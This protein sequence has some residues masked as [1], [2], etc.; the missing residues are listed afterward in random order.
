MYATSN[1]SALTN[2][3]I[4]VQQR[5]GTTITGL[6]SGV[7]AEVL[8]FSGPIIVN[9]LGT[10]TATSTA[11]NAGS[12]NAG[13]SVRDVAVAGDAVNVTANVVN[14]TRMDGINVLRTNGNGG[15]TITA[16]GAI[17]SGA[18]TN[19]LQTGIRAVT[20]NGS[21][22]P[23]AINLNSAIGSAADRAQIGG[24]VANA[25]PTVGGD[26]QV[27]L[28]NGSVYSLGTGIAVTES[29]PGIVSVTG[30]GTGAINVTGG[31]GINTQIIG[32]RAGTTTVELS[33]TINASGNAIVSSTQGNGNIF[34][35][36]ENTVT[37]G[38]GGILLTNAGPAGNTGQLI[39][40]Q[41]AGTT[42][43]A[44]TGD[45]I[46]TT[47]GAAIGGTVITVNGTVRSTGAD[48]VDASSNS[49]R[50]NIQITGAVGSAITGSTNGIIAAVNG[51]GGDLQ[52]TTRGSVAATAGNGI[53]ALNNSTA[54]ADTVTVQTFGTVTA[55][56]GDGI[57]ATRNNG[58]GA[59]TV[60][61]GGL[62]SSGGAGTLQNGILALNN[63]GG[64][65]AVTLNAN[66]GSAA[67][68]AVLAGVAAEQSV[69][70][71]AGNVTLALNTASVFATGG[72]AVRATQ[73]GDGAVTISETGTGLISS[74]NGKGVVAEIINGGPASI[75]LSLTHAIQSG[76]D[77]LTAQTD[78][79]G[80]L[81]VVQ[82]GAITSTNGVGILAQNTNAAASGSIINVSTPAGTS[83][84]AGNDAIRTVANLA[85]GGTTI[86]TGGNLSSTAGDGIDASSNSTRGNIAITTATGT[87]ITVGNGANGIL[88]QTLGGTGTAGTITVTNN[89]G[90]T[91]GTTSNGINAR[92]G[93]TVAGD[94]LTVTN[95]GALAVGS[96]GIL[97]SR[98][99]AAGAVSVTNS[100]AI[101]K[102]A[103]GATFVNGIN[104]ATNAGGTVTVMNTADI[105]AAGAGTSAS[106]LF[107][108][109]FQ[110]GGTDA[111]AVTNS[112]SIYGGTRGILVQNASGGNSSV[113]S[114]GTGTIAAASTANN[115]GIGVQ[116]N[117]LTNGATGN[118]TVDVTQAIAGQTGI[119]AETAGVGNIMVTARGNVTAAS[120]NTGT[121][122]GVGIAAQN[123][124][125][126]ANAGA[127]AV[128]TAAGTTVSGTNDAIRSVANLATGGTMIVVNGDLA[129][130]GGDGID[131]SSN[132]TRG[133]ITVMTAAGTTINAT[134][135][136]IR[137]AVNGAGGFLNVT[138]NAAV[139]LVA[140]GGY[141]IDAQD[142]S[143]TAG[144]AITITNTGALSVGLG[145]IL[146]ARSGASGA[147][148]VTNSG[149]ITGI[150]ANTFALGISATTL[151]GGNVAVT[152]TA[153]IGTAALPATTAGI[154]AQASAAGGTDTVNVT[155]SG[156]SIFGG[157][158]GI[159]ASNASGG[160]TSV[161]GTGIG[162]ISGTTGTGVRAQQMSA[163]S[164]GAV[165][166]D[167]TQVVTGQTGINATTAGTGNVTVRA[168]NAVTG[169]AG[170][171]I[172]A[173]STS[174]A[175]SGAIV[176]VTSGTGA[177]TGTSFGINATNTAGT[178]GV[179]V[180][181]GG[182]VS[183]STATANSIGINAVAQAGPATVTTTAGSTVT[184]R[185]G[186]V[187][188]AA[189][190]TAPT[191]VTSAAAINA[192]A[193][194]GITA[195]VGGHDQRQRHG[196][197]DRRDPRD[198]DRHRRDRHRDRQRPGQ[199]QRHDHGQSDPDQRH[200]R[201]EQ[202]RQHHRQRHGRHR[203]GQRGGDGGRPQRPGDTDH[204]HRRGGG[205]RHGCQRLWRHLRHHRQQRLGWRH[206]R[207]RHGC[208]HDLGYRR[209][210]HL[211]RPDDGG[212]DG[213]RRR[214]D[215]A[216]RDRPG[217]HP[218]ADAGRRQRDRRRRR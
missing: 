138:N 207:D 192:T 25:N 198:R 130:T 200:Q 174:M 18:T 110:A 205:D 49:T 212:G 83:I 6:N 74:T 166:V 188:T 218:G 17:G 68:R 150:A 41:D 102:V 84:A 124:D 141:G 163:G 55:A 8:G 93:S 159:L 23:I 89:A 191:L 135:D 51:T 129:S 215:R 37:A 118:V 85:S 128:T 75:N 170:P 158:Y 56:G 139:T 171:G 106:G 36:A 21:A 133:D 115:A 87:T 182:N 20:D 181:A 131:A 48:G 154:L 140:A 167:V 189:G 172:Q 203:R 43:T 71:A 38:A 143:T 199:F 50:G 151:N 127:I 169:T 157:Q 196:R 180:N 33:Q 12:N 62:I 195:A 152:T 45:A 116:V 10:V 31:D 201:H 13:I 120:G 194:N 26:V 173:Q 72:T 28:T 1:T 61:S 66:V 11:V 99:N 76:D 57:R 134:A 79:A 54:N 5:A 97:A 92:N 147:V 9:T 142:A 77:A 164:A 80:N 95:T 202:R 217:R 69:D 112:A 19:T 30:T 35:H 39:V 60:T 29:G 121:F 160:A 104:A 86:M 149:A 165:L 59:L 70:N 153:P 73:R 16:N 3:G 64:N 107:A 47:A 91:T 144:D 206:E 78:G 117:Q 4:N 32:N 114:T 208:R 52:I 40:T 103:A 109:A 88:A 94:T 213:Q 122:S 27:K 204:R 155:A 209:H 22:A 197:L 100:G 63:G 98:T 34:A 137:A 15:V 168:A 162:T 82:T 125:T 67:D 145:G 175:A 161:V 187:A 108:T 156:A 111:V 123:Y 113:N 58:A 184:G 46:N 214:R 193:G 186:I 81:T 65:V 2:V 216:G 185:T 42:L 146:A 101:T 176:A 44:G 7:R 132:S 24:I 90:I 190:L 136:G 14:A 53:V 210:R 96:N 126:A 148:T 178:G 119:Q 179:T 211:R 177:V 105:G 183:A